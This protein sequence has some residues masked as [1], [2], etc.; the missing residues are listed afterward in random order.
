[1]KC[2]KCPLQGSI[3][4]ETDGPKNCDLFVIQ[5]APGEDELQT[6]IPSSGRAGQLLRGTLSNL[7]IDAPTIGNSTQCR[8]PGVEALEA[9]CRLACHSRLMADISERN[10]K[11]ILALG[12]PVAKSLIGLDKVMEHVGEFY[13]LPET[14]IKV[15]V[16]L[17]PAFHLRSLTGEGR[18]LS[19][20]D[21]Y[22][23]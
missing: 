11:L 12:A 7:G 8:P 10:P 6:G 18:S 19:V 13:D 22:E 3:Q 21:L 4:V 15:L 14:D 20:N 5:E 9:E 17:N 16:G 1:M 2:E 23:S